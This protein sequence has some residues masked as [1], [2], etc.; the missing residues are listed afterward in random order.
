MCR[1]A[2]MCPTACTT[3]IPNRVYI[4]LNRRKKFCFVDFQ[5]MCFINNRS[6]ALSETCDDKNQTHLHS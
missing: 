2:P 6:L 3:A 5:I 1:I 4:T